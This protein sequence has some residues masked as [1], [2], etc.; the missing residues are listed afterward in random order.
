MNNQNTPF[1]CVFLLFEYSLSKYFSLISIKRKKIR[2]SREFFQTSCDF[3]QRVRLKSIH[4]D[5]CVFLTQWTEVKVDFRIFFSKKEKKIT[6][7]CDFKKYLRQKDK[8]AKKQR[9]E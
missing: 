7:K 6:L 8:Q 3:S 2:P 9:L 1:C 4:I 5:E